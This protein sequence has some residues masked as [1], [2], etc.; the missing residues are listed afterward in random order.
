M[1]TKFS[2]VATILDNKLT[3]M[4]ANAL[5]AQD[6][7]HAL[8]A[9]KAYLDTRHSLFLRHLASSLSAYIFAAVMRH[10]LGALSGYLLSRH[11]TWLENIDTWPFLTPEDLPWLNSGF[12]QQLIHDMDTNNPNSAR[13]L[14]A[15][16][17]NTSDVVKKEIDAF[18]SM[19]TNILTPIGA[20]LGYWVG[21]SSAVSNLFAYHWAGKEV[22]TQASFTGIFSTL[23]LG[24]GYAAE[25]VEVRQPEMPGLHRRN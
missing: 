15:I 2:T 11:A 19:T 7:K 5:D 20:A 25:G 24:C 1:T 18:N 4:N 23:G 3:Q 8:E 12:C 16:L 17:N 10:P 9:L 21:G 14:I 13:D 6:V 22:F